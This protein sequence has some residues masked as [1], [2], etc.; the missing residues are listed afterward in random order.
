MLLAL[1]LLLGFLKNAQLVVPIG[2]QGI[3]AQSGPGTPECLPEQSIKR[4]QPWA[5]MFVLEHGN[6]L[7]EGED[8]NCKFTLTKEENAERGEEVEGKS[9]HEA[10]VAAHITVL[11]DRYPL[12]RPRAVS[13]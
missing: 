10:D 5:R 1:I 8:L 4:V 3:G 13:C 7:P 12:R 2:F 9:Q 6:L 11:V